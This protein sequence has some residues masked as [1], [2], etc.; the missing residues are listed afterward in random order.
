MLRSIL[1]CAVVVTLVAGLAAPAFARDD[2]RSP[3]EH[4]EQRD[5]PA[6]KSAPHHEHGKQ[7]KRTLPALP[8][9]Q[10]YGT[11]NGQVV[12]V[13]DATGAIVAVLGLITAL[14]V[15]NQ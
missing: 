8:R 14:S 5:R 4:Q 7:A 1:T 10:H 2:W 3:P 11:H 15:A 12:R 13:D 9:G 6:Q